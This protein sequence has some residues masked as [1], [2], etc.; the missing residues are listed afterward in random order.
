MTKTILLFTLLFFTLT[1]STSCQT[2][3]NRTDSLQKKIEQIVSDKNAVVGISIIRN[4]GKGTISLHGDRR[5]P[6]IGTFACRANPPRHQSKQKSQS[7]P[8]Q[9]RTLTMQW[10][11]IK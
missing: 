10:L 5:F 8:P 3:N 9:A 2:L 4:N 6:A 1:I 11:R 7:K